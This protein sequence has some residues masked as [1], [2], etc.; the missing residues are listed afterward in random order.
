MTQLLRYVL[1]GIATNGLGYLV[2]LAVTSAGIE[3][4]TTMSVFYVIGA[5]LGFLATKSFRF[6]LQAIHMPLRC[7]MS[8]HMPSGTR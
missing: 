7:G 4:K 6:P 3:P 1:I 8:P 5:L 2:Y